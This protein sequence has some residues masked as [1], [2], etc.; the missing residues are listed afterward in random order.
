MAT[1]S[2]RI[3]ETLTVVGVAAFVAVVFGFLFNRDSTFSYSIGYNLYGAQRILEGQVPYRDFHTLYP[4]ATVYLNALLFRVFGIGLYQALLAVCVFKALTAVVLY[5]CARRVMPVAWSLAAAVFPIIWLRPNGPFKAVPMH[6][7]ALFLALALY[8][9][10]RFLEKESRV[11]LLIAGITLGI[12]AL[13]K[14]NIGAYALIGFSV[15]VAIGKQWPRWR[16]VSWPDVLRSLLVLFAGCALPVIPV[17]IYMARLHALGPMVHT[18]LFGPGEFLLKRLAGMPPPFFPALMAIIIA[19][20]A[21]LA[22]R[23]RNNQ[24]VSGIVLAAIF[25]LAA[26]AAVASPERDFDEL[27]FYAPVGILLA[28]LF[29]FHNAGRNKPSYGP[30]V[31]AVTVAGWAALMESFPR[32]ARE[33]AIAAL[34]FAGLLLIQLA[35]IVAPRVKALGARRWQTAVVIV[36][37]PAMFALMGLRTLAET[38]LTSGLSLRSDTELSVERGRGVY[39]PAELADEIDETVRYIQQQVPPGGAFFAHSYAGSSF[40][41]LADRQNPSAVQFWG[42]VGVTRSEQQQTLNA[43][44]Q[45]NIGLIVT[46]AN[47][48]SAE[49]FQPMK[50]Y[51]QANFKQTQKF[52]RVIIME[53]K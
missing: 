39:F 24:L 7:G 48:M 36:V 1:N 35:Y 51:I 44:Q 49:K 17:L 12:L 40:L 19:G 45:K 32:F 6:Y 29:I 31:L 11:N 26:I 4:P 33:Q 27:V 16:D 41:F 22:Y 42:G 34:P 10:I 9:V 43:L 18:L 3:K 37:L 5:L 28:G 15:V 30:Q 25:A 52:G 38:Y 2:D 50:E 47:D 8:F 14:H 20:L 23:A 13:F 21:I 53:R 46:T